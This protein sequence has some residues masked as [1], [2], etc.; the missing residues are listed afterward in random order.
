M[1]IQGK[2][3]LILAGAGVHCKVVRAAKEMG[4][5]TIVTDYLDPVDAPAKQIADE[6]WMLNITDIDAIVKKCKEEHVDGVLNF[7][8]DPAQIPYQQICERLNLPCYGTKE[9]FEILTDK[10]KFKD[11]CKANNVD[12]IP[13]FTVDDIEKGHAEYPL[14]IKP[15]QSRGSR[16]QRVCYSR[17]E[18][19]SAIAVARAE[20]LDGRFLCEKSLTGNRDIASAFYVVNGEPYL[21]KF[22]DRYLGKEEDNLNRQVMCTVLPSEFTPIF[23]SCVMARVKGMIKTLGIKF[24]PVFMQGFV[25]GD[26]IRFY[27]PALRMPGGGYDILL[28]KVTGFSTV[29]S[30]IH[31][32]LTGDKHTT[33][34]DPQAVYKLGGGCVT[35]VTVS[36]R[37]GKIFSIVGSE[38][39]AALPNVAYV[40][41]IIGRGEIVPD[42]GDIAQRIASIG[43]FFETRSQAGDFLRR[44]YATYQILDADGRNMVVSQ[45]KL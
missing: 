10:R 13:D 4:V 38:Q 28:E 1:D 17:D 2:K 20:S 36:A 35:L 21:V 18:A 30:L 45:V 41:Q 29:K 8:I 27:D 24:G 26:T 11:F 23:E 15:N 40:R 12:V 7:C 22:G 3:L 43:A 39:I 37:P 44:L 19:L 31:F 32:A 42:T 5:H 9:Q 14:F 16:G 25:D 34:G 6:Y 33:I